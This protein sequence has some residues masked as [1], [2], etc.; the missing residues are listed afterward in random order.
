MLTAVSGV[1]AAAEGQGLSPTFFGMATSDALLY[2]NV[3]LNA[4]ASAIRAA[5]T[6]V[7]RFPMY[8]SIA[9]PYQ[10]WSDV[11]AGQQ[12]QFTSVNGRPTSFADIDQHVLAF[13]SHGLRMLPTVLQAPPWAR[14]QSNRVWSPPRDTN[15]YGDFVGAVVRRYG[16]HGSFWQEH[17]ELARMAPNWWEIWNEPAGGDNPEGETWYWYGSKP[18]EP[19]YI[20]MLR[21]A[22][23]AARSADSSARIVLAGFFGRSWD[24]L[25]GIYRHG[26][27]GLFDVVSIHPYANTS[28]HILTILRN[29]RAT[30][31][32]HHQA[33]VPMAVTETTWLSS[34]PTRSQD[35]GMNVTEGEQ[36]SNLSGEYSMLVA[37]RRELN[38]RVLYWYTW[39]GS[40]PSSDA[41]DYAGLLR[42]M[43]DGTVEQKP[44]LH[45]YSTT[46]HRLER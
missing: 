23:T 33:A 9:Q 21:A 29:V 32:R 4:Q 44:A 43:P 10:S 38:L 34:S 3:D 40:E 30:L 28:D 7:I 24:A 36:A 20:A 22:R 45:A 26:G 14:V 8:W 12:D 35:Y 16:T 5:G 15:A 39:I 42:L 31:N 46:V 27:Q 6:G 2:G 18:Y 41:W 11:P 17:P 13:A 19:R 37:H 25:E 1:P